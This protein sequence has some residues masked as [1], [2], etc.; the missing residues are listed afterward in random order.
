MG[1]FYAWYCVQSS[2][3]LDD[4][5][6]SNLVVLFPAINIKT[7]S[8]CVLLYI[9]CEQLSC[10]YG[11]IYAAGNSLRRHAGMAFSATDRDND[12]DSWHCAQR[13]HGGWWFWSCLHSNLNGEYLGGEHDLSGYG[14][15][16]YHWHGH[17]Y[18]LKKVDMKLRP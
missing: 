1:M 11:I 7:T 2:V 16:W 14:V 4:L 10:V 6:Y 18:S 13:Y 12:L 15:D 9:H 5:H 3:C 17:K 8:L